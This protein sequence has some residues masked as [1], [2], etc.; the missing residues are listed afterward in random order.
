MNAQN[1]KQS[2][3]E[4]YQA[5]RDKPLDPANAH[6]AGWYVPYVE[7]LAYDPIT[8]ICN[9][10]GFNDTQSLYYVTGQR[11]TG[12]ST[13]LLR[14]RSMLQANGVV[15]F[16][17]DMLRYL[18]MSEPTEI[19]DFLIAV[20]AGLA[21]QARREHGLMVEGQSYWEKLKNF[22][23][24]LEIEKTSLKSS[25]KLPAVEF[26]VDIAARLKADNAFKQRLQDVTRGYT[27][28][29]VTQVQEF[30]TELVGALR[31]DYKNP[32]LQVAVIIDSFEQIR[33]YY[34]NVKQVYES[35]VKLF[36]ADGKHLR[37]PLMHTVITIPPYL[38]SI[39]I[40]A[41]EVPVS[42]PS[43][44]V[45]QRR[46]GESDPRGLS[47]LRDMIYYRTGAAREIFTDAILNELAIA[48]GGDIRD[49]FSLVSNMLVKAGTQQVLKLPLDAELARLSK[50]KLA[51][52]LQPIDDVATRW[53]FRVRETQQAELDERDKLPELA[54]LFDRN[55]VIHY[56][57]GENWYGIHPL[58]DSYVA[59]RMK[60][61]DGREAQQ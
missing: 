11:G 15:V 16:Y 59:E 60:V 9:E 35:V 43:V 27:T 48:S 24:R 10:I 44:H 54:L 3:K 25:L 36:G 55:L 13:E 33:G 30:A 58:I 51:R 61:L 23:S 57:N 19:S 53:L 6:D 1:P 32:G 56:Q 31:R 34:G 14:L 45:R 12:K 22:I 21:E 29:L 38:N 8:E 39:A 18:H 2:L 50:E 28:E 7:R 41:G 42:L 20:S 4:L 26:G 37:L 49:F 46:S 17:V 47:I 5:L 40:G 52:S